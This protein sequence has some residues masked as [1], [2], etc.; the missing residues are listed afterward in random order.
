MP[1]HWQRFDIGILPRR[2]HARGAVGLSN[3]VNVN[4]AMRGPSFSQPDVRR[5]L[6]ATRRDGCSRYA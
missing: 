3:L 1:V 4:T 2:R 6:D 5:C